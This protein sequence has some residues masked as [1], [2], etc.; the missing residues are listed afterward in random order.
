MDADLDPST[1][2]WCAEWLHGYAG[3]HHMA[4]SCADALLELIGEKPIA[5]VPVDEQDKPEPGE[6]LPW[7]LM[8]ERS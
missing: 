7:H 5:R 4:Q 8:G 2:R 1:V 6:V 3:G